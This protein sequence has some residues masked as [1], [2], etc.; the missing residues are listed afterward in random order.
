[1]ATPVDPV[2]AYLVDDLAALGGFG[3]AVELTVAVGS[4]VVVGTPVS[5]AEYFVHL[6]ERFHQTVQPDFGGLDFH[7]GTEAGRE[8]EHGWQEDPLVELPRARE[9][10]Y[11]LF[12][13]GAQQRVR[14]RVQGRPRRLREHPRDE[15]EEQALRDRLA[16]SLGDDADPRR[17]FLHLRDVSILAGGTV[18]GA[19]PYWRVRL[20]DVSAWDLGRPGPGEGLESAESVEDGA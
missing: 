4:L 11:R 5:D 7:N 12:G 20:S 15:Q 17:R 2:L 3:V 1:V 18:I 8:L 14:E 19:I 6:G 13:E 16:E 10:G 9:Q